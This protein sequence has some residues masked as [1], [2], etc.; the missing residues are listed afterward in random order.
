MDKTKIYGVLN[1]DREIVFI[2]DLQPMDW[3]PDYWVEDD[4]KWK[5]EKLNN[6]KMKYEIGYINWEKNIVILEYLDTNEEEIKKALDKW[7]GI[8]KPKYILD[9]ISPIDLMDFRMKQCR[10]W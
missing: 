6:K 10:D 7:I 9:Y 5:I 1:E 3:D 8:V 4:I 2:S